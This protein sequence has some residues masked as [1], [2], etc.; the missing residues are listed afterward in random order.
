MFV[1]GQHVDTVTFANKGLNVDLIFNPSDP[2]M[3]FDAKPNITSVA[4]YPG[5]IVMKFGRN[6]MNIVEEAANFQIWPFLTSVT[7]RLP[8]MPNRA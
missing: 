6:P 4:S 1:Y 3:T 2:H 8:L 7:S 5:T